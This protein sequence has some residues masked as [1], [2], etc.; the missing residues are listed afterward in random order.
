[1]Q[2]YHDTMPKADFLPVWPQAP[3][4]PMDDELLDLAIEGGWLLCG[5]P[6]DVAE[7]IAKYNDVG[8]DQLVFGVP[9]DGLTHDEVLECIELFGDK[10]IPEYDPDPVH[11]TTRARQQAVRRYA[12]FAHPVP[13]V[14]IDVLP[15]NALIQLDG[16]RPNG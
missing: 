9:S 10:V 1:V 12:D 14:H 5:T 15:R 16:S 13:D 3:A 4:G 2:L 6:E 7:Q 8:C 11:S